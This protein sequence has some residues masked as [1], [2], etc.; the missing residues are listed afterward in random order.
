LQY[1]NNILSYVVSDFTHNTKELIKHDL[2]IGNVSKF[3]DNQLIRD[4]LNYDFE[5]LPN[6]YH[7]ISKLSKQEKTDT[8]NLIDD[9]FSFNVKLDKIN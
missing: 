4:H 5:I 2:L 9:E 7:Y 6:Y 8:F 3:Q 1:E